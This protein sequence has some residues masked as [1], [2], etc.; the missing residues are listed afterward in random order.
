MKAENL[1]GVCAKTFRHRKSNEWMMKQ[2]NM[3][4]K[5][6]KLMEKYT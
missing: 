4:Y 1:F 2:Y 5:R 3:V 6:N